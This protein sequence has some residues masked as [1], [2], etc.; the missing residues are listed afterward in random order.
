MNKAFKQ[1]FFLTSL[2]IAAL[3]NRLWSLS[4]AVLLFLCGCGPKIYFFTA[5]ALTVPVADSA[6]LHWKIRGEPTLFV[7]QKDLVTGNTTRK[8]LEFT[9]VAEKGG[10]PPVRAFLQV[11]ISSGQ[12][13]DTLS[14]TELSLEG[15]S[16]LVAKGVKSPARWNA[17]EVV[18][19][20][21][22]SGRELRVVHESRTDVLD[23]AGS[24]S[25]A[26]SGLPYSGGWE[27]RSSLTAAERN[28]RGK[29]PA[30]LEIKAVVEPKK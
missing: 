3:A 24:F 7:H 14:L 27:L 1:I 5:D 17:F 19:L 30:L 21:S 12:R 29:L 25:G 15:D 22:A 26:L 18:K 23:A 11:E 20:A 28:D 4:P 2:K 16:V 6:R 9:L 13:T 10:K 8:I